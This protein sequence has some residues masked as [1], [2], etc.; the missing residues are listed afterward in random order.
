M[1]L[2]KKLHEHELISFLTERSKG[3][4]YEEQHTLIEESNGKQK[5][6]DY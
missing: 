2:G 5:K 4:Y 6:K 3:F 1:T